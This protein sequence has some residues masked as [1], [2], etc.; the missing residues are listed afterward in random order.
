MMLF[1]FPTKPHN[2]QIRQELSSSCLF[3]C[4]IFGQILPYISPPIR[5]KLV[6]IVGIIGACVPQSYMK[7]SKDSFDFRL[8]QYFEH[9]FKILKNNSYIS[10]VRYSLLLSMIQSYFSLLEK[11]YLILAEV[12]INQYS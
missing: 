4:N 8:Y 9:F 5:V 3:F 1:A 11:N 10:D 7:N 12:R 6:R 2:R